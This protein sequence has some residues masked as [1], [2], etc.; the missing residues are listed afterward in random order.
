VLYL[1]PLSGELMRR[2]HPLLGCLRIPDNTRLL[3]A[4]MVWAADCGLRV[5]TSDDQAAVE[6]YLN[7]LERVRDD[8]GRCLFA[9]APDVLG[10]AGAT[11][12]R[13]APLLP[14]IRA[15]GYPSALVA[16]DGF[17]AG[18]IDPDAFDVLFIGGAPRTPRSLEWKR[19]ETGGYAAIRWAHAQGKPVHV[20]R[21]NGEPYLRNLATL[22]VRS[23]DGTQLTYRSMVP[24]TLRW[25]ARLDGQP[26][27]LGVA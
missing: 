16:Q 27:L 9:V 21:E 12:E 20:G 19:S 24:R 4:D 25:L 5:A 7:W 8:R 13:S 23:V 3:P 1:S 18:A 11:W 22:G 26:S 14:R 15:L 17:D 10:D 2:R 6:R